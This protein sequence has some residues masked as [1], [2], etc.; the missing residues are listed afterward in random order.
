MTTK[1]INCPNCGKNLEYWT[2]G[3]FIECTGCRAQIQVEPCEKTTPLKYDLD[4]LLN[5]EKVF[6]DEVWNEETHDYYW[7]YYE[8]S[9]FT[10]E[11][12]DID[13]FVRS[14]NESLPEEVE[15]IEVDV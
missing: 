5:N 6:V 1:F 2:K 7:V 9:E 4:Y 15:L 13:G 14:Y 3:D 8:D 11:I 10:K 12:N